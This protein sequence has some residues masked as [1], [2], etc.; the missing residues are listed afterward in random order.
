MKKWVIAAA[1]MLS[2]LSAHA[3]CTTADMAGTWQVSIYDVNYDTA[4]LRACVVSISETGAIAGTCG[5]GSF[6]IN[7]R[8]CQ[9]KSTI[10]QKF[11]GRTEHIDA[12]SPL[13]PNLLM[14]IEINTT[15]PTS[16]QLTGFRLPQ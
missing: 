7:S 4:S 11:T 16:L 8:T 2:P 1:L 13:K 14:G 5:S 3:A 12:A 6:R 10:L 15:Q 9:W